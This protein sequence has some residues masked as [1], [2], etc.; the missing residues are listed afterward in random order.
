[1]NNTTLLPSLP[2]V[3]SRLVRTLL[4]GTFALTAE[5]IPPLSGGAEDLLERTRAIKGLADA[6]NVADG[7]GAS[8]HMSALASAAILVRE[9]IEPILQVTCRDRNKIALLSDLLGASGLGINNLLMLHGDLPE[10]GMFPETQGVYEAESADLI[11]WAAQMTNHGILPAGTARM[12]GDGGITP[13][14]LP[15]ATAPR[16]FVG[17]ADTPVDPPADW[18]PSG[19]EK[20]IKAGAQF[21]Q[22]QL[23]YDIDVVGRYVARLND[24]GLTERVFILI[25]T[26]PIASARSARWMNKNLWGVSV[27]ETIIDR[28]ENASDPKAEGIAFCLEFISQLADIQGVAGA[29]IMAP[30]NAAALPVVLGEADIPT[31]VKATA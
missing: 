31:R 28:L 27:P 20:K 17:G 6:V 4:D 23:C 3:E 22:T 14:T 25:G 11:R 13:E 9:G 1:M 19:L 26:S 10:T 21:I 30:G 29:H 15:L 5:I 2:P 16:F 24:L 8:V 18:R 12:T 7:A